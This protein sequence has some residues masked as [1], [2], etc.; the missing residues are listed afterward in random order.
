MRRI[1]PLAVAALAA[2]ML[3]S[4]GGG[5]GGPS[6]RPTG[7]PS[8]EQVRAAR[9][10]HV[11]VIMLENREYDRIVGSAKAPYLNELIRT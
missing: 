9:S 1:A 6:P 4:C 8:A 2:A 10:S 5:G 3:A 11:V 7:L